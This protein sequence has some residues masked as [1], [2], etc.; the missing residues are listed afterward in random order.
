M[1]GQG[2][3]AGHQALPVQGDKQER[4]AAHRD[5]RR[6]HTETVHARGDL[7]DDPEQ[8]EGDCRGV[9][10]QESDTRRRHRACILQRRTTSSDQGRRCHRRSRG[11]QDYQ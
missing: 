11:P 7:R 5:K 6:R 2:G 9:P 8:D 10:R 3:P 4:E 1:V